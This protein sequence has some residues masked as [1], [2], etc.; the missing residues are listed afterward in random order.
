VDPVYVVDTLLDILHSSRPAIQKEIISQL[1]GLVS[2]REQIRVAFALCELL[3]DADAQHSLTAAVL[4]ALGD[5][6]L[7]TIEAAELRAK[8]VK[9]I[10]NVP[11]ETIPVLLTFVFKRVGS[12]ESARLIRE[13][14]LNFDRAFSRNR[15]RR[16]LS[17][18]TINDCLSLAVESLQASL[19]RSKALADTWFKGNT[20]FFYSLNV[21]TKFTIFLFV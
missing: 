6:S 2:D 15:Q 13:V 19:I 20:F 12:E 5:L 9:R 1:P 16:S 3:D 7:P 14:R 4:D 18:E 10:L 8:V 11:L 21:I 17:E